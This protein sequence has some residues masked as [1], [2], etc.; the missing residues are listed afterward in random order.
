[1]GLA[2]TISVARVVAERSGIHLLGVLQRRGPDGNGNGNGGGAGTGNGTGDVGWARTDHKTIKK[3]REQKGDGGG[4]G[5]GVGVE[6]CSGTD[7]Y[8]TTSYC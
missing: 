8:S 3:N 5:W 1:M 4:G 7:R 6:V 2:V